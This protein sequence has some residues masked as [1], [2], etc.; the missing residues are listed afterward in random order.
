MF[1]FALMGIQSIILK[2]TAGVVVDIECRLSNNL[3]NIVIVGSAT[4]AVSEARERIRGAFGTS[5]IMLPRKRI[6]V[7]LA[8]ADIPKGDSGFD[9]AIA[10]AILAAN[11]QIQL[12]EQVARA[13]AFIGE[14]G[15]DGST[16]AVRG[17]IGK[18]LAGRGKGF[19]IFYIPAANLNQAR[20]VPN[21]RLVPITNL[22]QLYRY[23]AGLTPYQSLATGTGAYEVAPGAP[24]QPRSGDHI[25]LSEIVGQAQAKRALEIAAAGGHN[26]F[27]DGPPGTGKSMLAK[28]LP[29]LL[30]PPDREEV[31]EVTQLHSLAGHDYEKIITDRP[32]R[33]P[34]HSASRTAVLGGGGRCYRRNQPGPPGRPVL[35]RTAGI[36]PGNPGS[37]TPTP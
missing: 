4:R 21:V 18:I 7:N 37:T 20:L 22:L 30:P 32:F 11:Q 6:T 10:V 35:R 26:V 23:L 12:E 1:Y 8:P 15:L 33:A 2:G 27:F 31:V 24:Q 17:I 29:G 5:H 36:R 28:A 34:H 19:T 9:L 25:R 16:R 13:T 14:L 3:P